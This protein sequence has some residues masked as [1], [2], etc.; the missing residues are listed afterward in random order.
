[1]LISKIR[2]RQGIRDD[3]HASLWTKKAP[4]STS[5]RA[6]SNLFFVAAAKSYESRY[7]RRYRGDPLRCKGRRALRACNAAV[8]VAALLVITLTLTL[9]VVACGCGGSPSRVLPSNPGDPLNRISIDVLER[10][11]CPRLLVRTFP[12]E[13]TQ[14]QKASTGRLWV[15]RCAAKQREDASGLLDVSVD[16][17]GWQWASESSWG[18]GV[19]E[20]VYFTAAVYAKLA[21]E[22]VDG[23]HL[24]VWA[25]EPANV[26]VKEIGRVSAHSTHFA[27][28]IFGFASNI[29]GQ[30]PNSLATAALRGRVRDLIRDRSQMGLEI[31]LGNT[32]PPGTSEA[33]TALLDE[34]EAL[35]PGGALL[36]GSYPPDTPTEIAFDVEGNATVLARAVC[37]NEAVALVDSVIEGTTAKASPPKNV[38]RLHGRGKEILPAMPCAWILVTGVDDAPAKMKIELRAHY[39][40]S[41]DQPADWADSPRWV[42]VTL[43]SFDLTSADAKSSRLIAF[44]I[45]TQRLGQPMTSPRAEAV[46]LTPANLFE[47]K[48]PSTPFT[49]RAT[50]LK[51]K[52]RSWTDSTT[53]Y[54]SQVLG[55]AN[56]T[57]S[58]K[59][60]RSQENVTLVDTAT[61]AKVGTARI[62]IE[63][64]PV[65]R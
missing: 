37:A 64:L 63:M 23:P 39:S 25:V 38:H 27:S 5:A 17:L 43:L 28:A 44:D 7:V 10:E 1:M 47:L 21:A 2:V 52:S 45:G 59:R 54:E 29:L 34:R 50:S 26:T 56:V 31:A 3:A 41:T 46:W 40:S 6:R 12:L 53:N 61:G 33:E 22:I 8:A 24:K 20:Y 18:F 9:M 19:Q 48:T 60:A 65:P 57:V 14:G 49:L 62:A 11:A 30:P 42:R 58:G 16:V 32:P 36:S 4:G 51:P 55:T 35:F 13:D 15:R